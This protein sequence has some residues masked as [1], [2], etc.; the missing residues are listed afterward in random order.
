VTRGLQDLRHAQ[1]G[2]QDRAG[3]RE[4]MTG[5]ERGF[6]CAT[7]GKWDWFPEFCGPHTKAL[8]A[9]LSPDGVVRAR[10]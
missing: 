7:T 10:P 2:I 9:Q 5:H 3:P 6:S 1:G 8:K 4:G